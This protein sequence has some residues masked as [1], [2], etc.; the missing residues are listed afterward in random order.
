MAGKLVFITGGARSGKSV[1]AEK[2]AISHDGRVAY[3]ATAS[4]G[5]EEMKLRIERHRARRP[6]DWAT[7]ECTAGLA[8]SIRGASAE[9]DLVLVDCLTVYLARLLPYLDDAE[10]ATVQV[11]GD[12]SRR[13]DCE[14]AEIL[15]TIK[16]LEADVIIVS[17]EVGGGLVPPY[18]SGRLYRDMIG[19]ANQRIVAESDLAYAVIAGIPIDL[20]A[21]E[22]TDSPWGGP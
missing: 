4:A 9:H 21:C 3:V 11:E 10:P 14:M 2:L 16:T 17:N 7:F 22:A 6:S 12:L 5:D 15:E 8:E 13:L 18:P 1:F 19:R 20:K